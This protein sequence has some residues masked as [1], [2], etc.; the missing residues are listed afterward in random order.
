MS[1][2]DRRSGRERRTAERHGTTVDVTWRAGSETNRGTIS[3]IS[4]GGCFILCSGNVM[5]NEVVRIDL[6]IGDELTVP[7]NGEV[8]NYVFEI[9]FAAKFIDVSDQDIEFIDRF[10][11]DHPVLG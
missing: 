1:T 5:E 11:K 8:T 2:N 6:P 7:I 3:D 4:R 10:I 9:G